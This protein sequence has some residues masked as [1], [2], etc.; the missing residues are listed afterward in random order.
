M[1]QQGICQYISFKRLFSTDWNIEI[2]KNK[3]T[4]LKK[5]KTTQ[6]KPKQTTFFKMF[7]KWWRIKNTQVTNSIQPVS[8]NSRLIEENTEDSITA[9]SRKT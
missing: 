5:T 4:K 1:E 3:Y 6:L 7:Y 9:K 2:N 8:V